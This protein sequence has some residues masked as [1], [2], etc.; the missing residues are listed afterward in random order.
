MK[1]IT[2][3][4][5]TENLIRADG[6]LNNRKI[7]KDMVIED[8]YLIYHN[9]EKPTCPNGH[10][11]VFVSFSKGYK[12]SCE[13]KECT[14]KRAYNNRK[15]DYTKLH[16]KVRKTKLERYGN[17]NY[18]NVNKRKE[19]ISKNK[20]NKTDPIKNTDKLDKESIIKNFL[21]DGKVDIS[22]YKDSKGRISSAKLRA[23][24]ITSEEL[25][26]L[27]HNMDTKPVCKVCA[28]KVDYLGFQRGYNEVCSIKCSNKL[29]S[30]RLGKV[31]DT[32][33]FIKKAIEV[34]GDVYDYSKVVYTGSHNE[35][36]IICKEHG[37]F[38]QM[39]YHHTNGSSCLKCSYLT[40][41]KDMSWSRE[42]YKNTPAILYYIRLK[43][44]NLYKIGITS[45]SVRE[46]FTKEEYKNIEVISEE[47]FQDGRE[48]F[49]KEHK[50]LQ[51]N[52]DKKYKGERVLKSGNT[53]LFTSP[54]I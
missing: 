15:T 42:R 19:T 38:Q 52:R 50:I 33:S 9:M 20:S 32:E 6:K 2:K 41:Y 4:Y 18:V 45:R 13:D 8:L 31:H 24:G 7:T 30:I 17:E 53:E 22:R 54:I 44:E 28:K 39:P 23:D 36:T 46:R 47:V 48:A 34:H 26:L 1:K 29:K 10:N 21:I 14:K 35:V 12:N 43:K 3:Q 16:E 40:R 25:Y 27:Y 37:E 5:I 51:E 49:D 11:L